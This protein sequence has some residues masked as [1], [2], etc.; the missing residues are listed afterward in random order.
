MCI[1]YYNEYHPELN[2]KCRKQGQKFI[3]ITS[4]PWKNAQQGETGI[5]YGHEHQFSTEHQP[6][7]IKQ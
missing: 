4:H 2:N 7:Y 5:F 3:Y 1:I 6:D